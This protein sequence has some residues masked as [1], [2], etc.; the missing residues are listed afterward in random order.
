MESSGE[1]DRK[2]ALSPW[3]TRKEAAVVARV[4]VRT[5]DRAIRRGELE[6]RCVGRRRLT[7]R[8]WI[9]EW[10]EVVPMVAAIADL[11]SV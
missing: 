4:S 1:V 8:D 5:V 11:A 9:A 3:L 2:A 7:H 6:S 10:L